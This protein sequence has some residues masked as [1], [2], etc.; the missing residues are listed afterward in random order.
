MAKIRIDTLDGSGGFDAYVAEP[1]GTPRAA[2][3]VI[4]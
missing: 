3:I 1:D 2:I 4:Q